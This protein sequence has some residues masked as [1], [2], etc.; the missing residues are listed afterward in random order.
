MDMSRRVL[1]KKFLFLYFCI[2]T[3]HGTNYTVHSTKYT[4]HSTNYTV[5]STKY[6]LHSTKYNYTEQ[7]THYTVQGFRDSG[8]QLRCWGVQEMGSSGDG[9]SGDGEFRRCGIYEMR[10]SGEEKFSR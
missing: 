2:E 6:T 8:V 4:L 7:R 9:S 10:S 1:S 5:H 3:L